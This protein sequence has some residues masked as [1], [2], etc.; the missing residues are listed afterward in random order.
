[1]ERK[2][3]QDRASFAVWCG[4]VLLSGAM[5][6]APAGAAVVAQ[7]GFNGSYAPD[8][9][10]P[11]LDAGTAA[12]GS[13]LT[14]ATFVS[15]SY[16]GAESVQVPTNA[17]TVYTPSDYSSNGYYAFTL[18]P[19]AGY[20]VTLSSITWEDSTTDNS[21]STGG[22]GVR[23]A[24]FWSVDA[25]RLGLLSYAADPVVNGSWRQGT[26]TFATPYTLTGPVTFYLVIGD[27][28]SRGDR[29]RLIDNVV[30]NGDAVLSV[31][32]PAALP[33]GLG[34]MGLAGWASRRRR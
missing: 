21:G 28:T 14:S 26:A 7:Y 23:S 11:G 25:T 5:L 29:Y 15:R 24:L 31:P 18:T 13:A 33:A 4:S 34:L 27:N 17:T 6:T 3:K 22:W 30:V 32:T 20:T 16:E 10:V 1:M 19:Q 8:T 12:P 9:T 2:I